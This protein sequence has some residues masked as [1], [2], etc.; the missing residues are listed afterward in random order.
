M[1][2]LLVQNIGSVVYRNRRLVE[3]RETI[4][5]FGVV[6]LT[7]APKGQVHTSDTQTVWYASKPGP[8]VHLRRAEQ[9]AINGPTPIPYGG[10]GYVSQ[11]DPLRG[12]M[13]TKD[14]KGKAVGLPRVGDGIGPRHDSWLLRPG[15]D[16]YTFMG[17]D[18]VA[19]G[20]LGG[21]QNKRG[22][23]KSLPPVVPVWVN[24]RTDRPIWMHGFDRLA[25]SSTVGG[26]ASEGTPWINM[27]EPLKYWIV[28]PPKTTDE[29]A[30]KLAYPFEPIDDGLNHLMPG[31]LELKEEERPPQI[32]DVGWCQVRESGV[33]L[34]HFSGTLTVANFPDEQLGVPLAIGLFAA[35][36]VT[37]TEK[38]E[39]TDYKG[40]RRIKQPAAMLTRRSRVVGTIG[41]EPSPFTPQA[42]LGPPKWEN[43]AT[44][45]IIE[46]D[47][48]WAFSF[49]PIGV[50]SLVVYHWSVSMFRIGPTTQA[51][52]ETFWK[53]VTPK[54]TDD[55]ILLKVPGVSVT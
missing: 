46:L 43:A 30:R 26:V 25:R 38:Q 4:P 12:C 22:Q 18:T 2:G 42:I 14:A 19:T 20:D 27:T 47:A 11:A 28:Q 32:N 24:R 49:L 48:G 44:A 7:K 45:S 37:K 39:Q 6:E 15:H 51:S 40:F 16:A 10:W 9:L 17:L 3:I 23:W 41:S 5:P 55:D 52:V 50:F 36:P 54:V 8:D 33:Y 13:A 53:S 34:V 21:R 35:R 31:D 29:W 1:P